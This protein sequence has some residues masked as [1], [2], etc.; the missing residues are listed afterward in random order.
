ML[1]LKSTTDNDPMTLPVWRKVAMVI[2]ISLAAFQGNF[3]AGAHLI[4]FKPMSEYFQVSVTAIAN[5]IG[6]GILGVGVGSLLWSPLASPTGL[7]RRNTTLLAWGFYVALTFW[8]AF[9]KT[10]SS[11]AASRFLALFC[12]SVAQSVPA[13]Q[14]GETFDRKYKGTAVSAWALLMTLGPISTPLVGSGL[15]LIN[16][17]PQAFR[18]IYY[19]VIATAAFVWILMFFFV[20]ETA[21]IQPNAVEINHNKAQIESD[22]KLDNESKEVNRIESAS[23]HTNE[24]D[25]IASRARLSLAP[26]YVLLPLP[27]LRF[28]DGRVFLCG[29]MF[30]IT[31]GWTVGMTIINPQV[32]SQAPWKFGNVAIGG[33]YMSA[34]VGAIIGKLLGGY[35]VDSGLIM[36]RKN[37]TA[38]AEQRLW[39]LLIFLPFGIVGLLCYGFGIGQKM[40]WPVSIIP[41]QAASYLYFNIVSSVIQTYLV[42]VEPA[43]ATPVITFMNLVKCVFSFGVPFFVPAWALESNPSTG[44]QTSFI[45][46]MVV[47]VVLCFITVS[48][49]I[50]L[51]NG[52]YKWQKGTA[53]TKTTAL[54]LQAPFLPRLNKQFGGV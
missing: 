40:Q 39:A 32:F 16:P 52:L 49:A 31:F 7:G 6:I 9:A 30:A 54:A 29:L 44:F 37:R 36:W 46:Q 51:R 28:F 11:F 47:N 1:S 24:E 15:L 12:A 50:F 10:F 17:G 27:L 2:V 13:Q 43:S 19:F 4:A 48:L 18:N 14:I 5:T 53:D 20:P 35:I 41:G 42:E 8:M 33:L 3:A 38:Y 23:S 22:Q 26:W 25:E 21:Y 45:I 34:F